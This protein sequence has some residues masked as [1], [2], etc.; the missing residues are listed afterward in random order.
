MELF[1]LLR[2]CPLTQWGLRHWAHHTITLSQEISE[3][4]L[5][6]FS[7]LP[8]PLLTGEFLRETLD[9]SLFLHF[10]LVS[11]RCFEPIEPLLHLLDNIL[12]KFS[13]SLFVYQSIKNHQ[14]LRIS[15]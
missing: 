13:C 12:I 10:V 1:R 15:Q 14:R 6:F 9:H 11:V 4:L 5:E 8:L 2:G 3:R 7:L